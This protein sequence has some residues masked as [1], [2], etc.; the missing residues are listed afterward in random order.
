MDVNQFTGVG[1]VAQ[2][3]R[4]DP[5]EQDRSARL[6]FNLAIN[7]QAKDGGRGEV[8]YIPCLVAGNYAVAIVD[9]IH[10]GKELAVV[11]RVRTRKVDHDDGSFSKTF[12]I[13]VDTVKFGRDGKSQRAP[14]APADDEQQ[15]PPPDEM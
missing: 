2:D 14:E 3:P 12:V 9:Y 5:Q 15:P 6:F 13:F 10:K 8:N 4:F 11:G 1:R 7:E